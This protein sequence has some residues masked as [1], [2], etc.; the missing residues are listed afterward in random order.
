MVQLVAVVLDRV[1]VA[2]LFLH[3][4]EVAEELCQRLRRFDRVL[5]VLFEQHEEF[6]LFWQ[7]R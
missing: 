6:A 1:D 5:G 7:E 4:G 3:L 2:D